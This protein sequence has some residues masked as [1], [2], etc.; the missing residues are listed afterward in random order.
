MR[1]RCLQCNAYLI[2][3]VFISRF[4]YIIPYTMP[5]LSRHVII[6][7]GEL[8]S[9]RIRRA[10]GRRNIVYQ[11]NIIVLVF[12]LKITFG[13]PEIRFQQSYT[14]TCQI[15]KYL[16]KLFYSCTNIAYK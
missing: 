6:Q 3:F 10:P 11:Y 15:Q 13:G 7:F 5:V 2:V 4:D 1:R 14:V 9:L 16:L 8:N 12:I